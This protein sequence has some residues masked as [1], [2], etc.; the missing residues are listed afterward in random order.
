[1]AL[2]ASSEAR[3]RGGQR[4]CAWAELLTVGSRA[5]GWPIVRALGA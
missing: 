4:G 1:M 2:L 5:S 3:R